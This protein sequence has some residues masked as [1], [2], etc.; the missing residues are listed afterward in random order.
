MA[1]EAFIHADYYLWDAIRLLTILVAVVLDGVFL[2]IAW[3]RK[4]WACITIVLFSF[5]AIWYS[6]ITLGEDFEILVLGNL[7]GCVTG[8]VHII[9]RRRGTDEFALP[10]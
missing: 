6:A 1:A 2:S 7:A 4:N 10:T 5:T 8:L 9:K 3:H